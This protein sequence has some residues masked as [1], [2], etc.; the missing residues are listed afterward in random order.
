MAAFLNKT[1]AMVDD[2]ATASV[3]SWGDNNTTFVVWN[4]PVFSTLILP[5][6]FKHNNFSSFIRQLNTYVIGLWSVLLCLGYMGLHTH[7]QPVT[8]IVVPTLLRDAA[9][10]PPPSLS[11]PPSSLL[12]H[13][14]YFEMTK[15]P[16]NSQ[17]LLAT[18]P[19][20][21]NILLTNHCNQ[22]IGS[23]GFR[24]VDPDRWEFAHEGFLRGQK[25]L[26]KSISRQKSAHV[27][28][29]NKE[30]CQV[31]NSPV[32]KC[33]EV[34][35]FGLKEQV[36]RLKKDKNVIM[37]EIVR[38]RQQQQSTDNQ[39]QNIAQHVQAMEQRQQQMMSFL[40]KA[41]HSPGFLSQ[42][43]QQQNDSDIQITEI[44]RKRRSHMQEEDSAATKNLHISLDGCV[45]KYQPFID[46]AAKALFLQISQMN[47]STRME[48]SIKN[49]DA[50]T[51]NDVPSAIA[52]DNCS[53]STQLS[54]LTLSE[55][56]PTSVQSYTAVESQL[57]VNC[58]SKSRT[59]VQSSPAVLT[60]CARAS[61]IS[62][63][64]AHN[65]QDNILD[66]GKVQGM[67]T[68][69]SFIN[70]GLNFAG[71]DI[72]NVDEINMMPTVLYGTL[73]V[74][75]DA[76]LPDADGISMLPGI[77]ELWDEPVL[78]HQRMEE[79][80]FK[81][82]GSSLRCL[83]ALNQAEEEYSSVE[84]KLHAF[85]ELESK[86]ISGVSARQSWSEQFNCDDVVVDADA[87]V[88]RSIEE[89]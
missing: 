52:L 77:N 10:P 5:Q 1:Y 46:D 49:P 40:A 57:P 41:M 87:I 35:T 73:S 55:V 85:I 23:L 25:Q 63:L 66:F 27:N 38:L 12:H 13:R 11:L 65:C 45:A 53:S 67:G 44:N 83:K 58:M 56:L 32:G 7:C 68:E 86:I 72:G 79:Y 51:I 36:E 48:S 70:S 62:Q 20:I 28:G 78:N 19:Q 71:L 37:Q 15:I 17:A 88:N 60:D 61:E 82:K 50:F 22:V 29:C 75:A 47:N 69:D 42:F 43:V 84:G 21:N 2:S 30:T 9:I 34:G 54:G 31:Q 8:A 24:K 89:E 18:C 81:V 26:L 14:C 6:Y 64:T 16:G 80:I 39:L 33:I 59:E 74:E 3:V 76:F 4:V